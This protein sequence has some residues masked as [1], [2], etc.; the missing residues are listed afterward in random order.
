MNPNPP[1]AATNQAEN[2]NNPANAGNRG[3]SLG[4]LV[5]Q[6][7]TQNFRY[8]DSEKFAGAIKKEKHVLAID[9]KGDWRLAQILEVRLEVPF[10]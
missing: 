9:R 10:D 2:A 4:R 5:E 3:K 8:K 7:K 1:A 6:L